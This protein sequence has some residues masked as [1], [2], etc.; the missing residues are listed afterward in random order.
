M[1]QPNGIQPVEPADADELSGLERRCLLKRIC[2]VHQVIQQALL[3]ADAARG[4]ALGAP[5]LVVTCEALKDAESQVALAERLAN[6][7]L[8]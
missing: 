2:V 6:Q 4:K 8:H 7:Q 1:T 5:D 3:G